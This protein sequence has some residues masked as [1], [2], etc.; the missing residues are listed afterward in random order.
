M[1]GLQEFLKQRGFTY[2]TRVQIQERLKELNSGDMCNGI[3][4][5]KDDDSGKWSNIRVWWIPEFVDEEIEL[6]TE[7]KE[8]DNVPF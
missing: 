3:Y 1:K 2:F 8:D 7:E 6:T 4:K 5:L